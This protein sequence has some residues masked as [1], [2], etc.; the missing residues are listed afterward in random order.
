MAVGATQALSVSDPPFD[1]KVRKDP[2]G[3]SVA[4]MKPP[5]VS[6]HASTIEVLPSGTLVA[7]WFSGEKEEAPGCA[8]VVST[9]PKGT[10]QWTDAITVSKDDKYSNQNPV[11][12]YDDVDS[13]LH[14]FHSH[15]PA[16]SGESQ[17]TIF[18][19]SSADS[20]ATWTKPEEWL[21][22]PGGFPRNRIIPA[23]DGG[24]IFPFYNAS[25]APDYDN[26]NY[27]IIG[28]SPSNRDWNAKNW[29]FFGIKG[30]ADLVQPSTVRLKNQSLVTF[31]RDRRAQNIYRSVADENAKHFTTPDTSSHLPNNNAGI[32]AN[33]IKTSDHIVMA[34]N[35]QTSG[36]DP[37]GVA[38]S[39]DGGVTWPHKRDLQHGDSLNSLLS[40]SN[41]GSSNGNEFSYPST[42]ITYDENNDATIHVTYT[43]NR[44]T[45][46]YKRFKESWISDSPTPAPAPP[47][48]KWTCVAD[49]DATG[50]TP[51][52][53]SRVGTMKDLKEC[54]A[55]CEKLGD[56][57]CGVFDWNDSSGHCYLRYDALWK[58]APNPRVTSCCLT[59]KVDHCGKMRNAEENTP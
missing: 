3:S 21:S 26:H 17:S 47:A 36:R 46:K 41:T 5:Y 6:N 35:P 20:G 37:L 51:G 1:G 48:G 28:L 25:N 4:Y 43:Y 31:F 14:L 18:H 55:A 13:K 30:S 39:L 58:T 15:A 45:I 12:F 53:Y 57:G 38:V 22:A 10:D 44:Q 54:Q 33:I 34:Y 32:E 24:V 2:D 23:A 7:A 27:A 49:V 11:L 40:D 9:L 50:Q 29:Q 42:L 52:N 8:I 59:D 16:E 19:L 56:D